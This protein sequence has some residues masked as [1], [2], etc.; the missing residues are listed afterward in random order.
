MH[1]KSRAV[2]EIIGSRERLLSVCVFKIGKQANVQDTDRRKKLI[3]DELSK[4]NSEVKWRQTRIHSRPYVKL[5]LTLGE[6]LFPVRQDER[7][8]RCFKIH[9]KFKV[10]KEECLAIKISK[11][12]IQYEWYASFSSLGFM[13]C[14]VY[15]YS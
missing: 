8:R 1:E 6:G 2:E 4:D 11:L 10:L 7:S 14:S 15:E 13:A 12:N 5:F 9:E 3:R